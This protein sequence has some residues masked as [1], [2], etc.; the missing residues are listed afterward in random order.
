M[1]DLNSWKE[2]LVS[3]ANMSKWQSRIER[4]RERDLQQEPVPSPHD[5]WEVCW[6]YK[7]MYKVL[8]E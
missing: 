5:D 7:V 1:N 2:A 8:Q 3:F 6:M 4:E